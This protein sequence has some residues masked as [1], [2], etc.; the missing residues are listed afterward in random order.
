MYTTSG[1]TIDP[2]LII[3]PRAEAIA[4]SGDS[5]FIGTNENH[6]TVRQ[7]TTSGNLVNPALITGL[8]PTFGDFGAFFGDMV[9]SKDNLFVASWGSD[10]GLT[11]Q[12][13]VGEYTLSGAP[14]DADLITFGHGI[15]TALAVTNSN[16]YV[17]KTVTGEQLELDKIAQYTTS[18]RLIDPAFIT[19]VTDPN[20]IAVSGRDI[21]IANG[22]IGG[23]G[24]GKYTT[25]GDPVDPDLI[26][27]LGFAAVAVS[28][29]GAGVP[30][31]FS[32]LWLALPV[33]GIFGIAGTRKSQHPISRLCN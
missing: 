30:E 23:G 3:G 31:P 29:T 6:G 22:S 18:G 8:Q 10:N 21:F 25:S 7:Y 1:Q 19:G 32:S 11:Y 14:V 9:I 5:I 16:I 4:V 33:L 24:I 26:S 13:T 17:R 27:N 15:A 20:A 28:G 12:S 2:S